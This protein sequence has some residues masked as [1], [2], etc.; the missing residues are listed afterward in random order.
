MVD[1]WWLIA[2]AALFLIYGAWI[3]G[4]TR[5]TALFYALR[6]PEAARTELA[7]RCGAIPESM[8]DSPKADP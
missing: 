6:N 1:W 7:R 2:E 5:A 8:N 3:R 4:A